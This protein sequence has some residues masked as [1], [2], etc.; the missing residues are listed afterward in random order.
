MILQC[1]S[2]ATCEK[3]VVLKTPGLIFGRIF[4]E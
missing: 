3:G 2:Y 4:V 1:N